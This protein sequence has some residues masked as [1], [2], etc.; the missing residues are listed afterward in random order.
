[1][2]CED[3]CVANGG[4]CSTT[5]GTIGVSNADYMCSGGQATAVMLTCAQV[6]ASTSAGC[7]I[8]AHDCCCDAKP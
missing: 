5:C 8:Y 7:P 4:M 2:S 1:M 6:P 3:I